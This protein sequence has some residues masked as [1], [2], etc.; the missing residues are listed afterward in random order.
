MACG[1]RKRRPIIEVCSN[2]FLLDV[3]D[4]L[5][6]CLYRSVRFL[7]FVS[8]VCAPPSGFKHTVQYSHFGMPLGSIIL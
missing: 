3:V 7:S 1:F 6:S 2:V 8:K 5:F 4:I